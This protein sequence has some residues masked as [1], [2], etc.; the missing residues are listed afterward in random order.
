M[1]TLESGEDNIPVKFELMPPQEVT[2]FENAMTNFEIK[3][4]K[5]FIGTRQRDQTFVTEHN[6]NHEGLYTAMVN[7]SL[8]CS[9]RNFTNNSHLQVCILVRIK[10]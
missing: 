7:E 9:D 2:Y 3:N 6:H 10:L 4:K 5:I 1:D 8:L